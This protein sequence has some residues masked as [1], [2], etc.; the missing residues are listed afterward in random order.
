MEPLILPY[1]DTRP[2]VDPTA[3]IAPTAVLIGETAIGGGAG[4]Y[5]HCVLRGDINRIEVGARTNIQ[6]LSMLHVDDDQPC[7]VGSEVTVGH[8]A[9]LHGCVIEDHDKRPMLE[10]GEWVGDG[11]FRGHA[12][13]HIWAAYSLSPNATWGQIAAEFLESKALGP[14][15]LKTF[16]N[17]VL[18]ETWRE[19]GES[20]DWEVLYRRREK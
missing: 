14:E 6:D 4:V 5:F 11:E 20:P 17:T 13:F 12:S 7:L 8:R 15:K 3:F 16:V 2:E 19:R 1:G 18:G 9:I 10:R